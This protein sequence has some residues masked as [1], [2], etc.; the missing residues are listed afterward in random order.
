MSIFMKSAVVRLLN[1]PPVVLLDWA[2]VEEFAPDV[3]GIV[4]ILASLPVT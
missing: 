1:P 3:E 2:A 4:L